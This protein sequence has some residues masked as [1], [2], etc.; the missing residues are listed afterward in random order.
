MEVIPAIDLRAGRCV[1]LLQGDYARE[2]VFGDDP[3]AIARHWEELG[4]PRLHVVDLDGARTGVPH[5]V[6]S[7][8]RIVAAVSIPVQV[9]GGLRTLEHASSYLRAGADRIIFGTAAVKDQH[10]IGEALAMDAGAI[11][12]ALDARDGRVQLEGWL[13]GSNLGTVDL[14]R[15]M[16]ALGVRRLL[17]TDI[18]RDGMLTEPNYEALSELR[19]AT[20]MAVIAS[21]GV[22]STTQLLR[23]AEIGLEAAIVGR[24]LYTGDLSL[25]EALA[26]LVRGR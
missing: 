3:V 23:L 9:G 7:I 5:E 4:A 12:V 13:E 21:G 18:L 22:S 25:T 16:E 1:R 20:S 17:S 11:V 14:A 8:E 10:L 26:A 24:A 6:E 2:I 15:Q 19:A